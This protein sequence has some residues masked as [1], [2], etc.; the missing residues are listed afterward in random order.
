M[1]KCLSTAPLGINAPLNDLIE[2]A[3]SHGVKKRELDVVA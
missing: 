3:L 1:C 2:Q